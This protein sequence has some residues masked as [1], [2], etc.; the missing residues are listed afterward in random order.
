MELLDTGI[1]GTAFLLDSITPLV[2]SFYLIVLNIPFYLL[3]LKKLGKEFVVYSLFAIGVFSVFIFIFRNVLP[4]DF[5]N[6]SPFAGED[7]LLCALF[8]GLLS[9]LG[10]GFVI[11]FG[12]AIDGVEVMAVLFAKRLSLTVGTFVMCYNLLIYTFSGLIFQ[13]WLVPMYSVIAYTVGVKTID[14][15]VE[16]LDKAKAVFIVTEKGSDI[17]NQLTAALGRGVTTLD[18][19]GVY[20][21]IGKTLIYCVA[22]RFEIHRIKTIVKDSDDSAFVTISDVSE[23][24]GGI[25]INLNMKKKNKQKDAVVTELLLENEEEKLQK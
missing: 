24:V 15:V 18:A 1:S 9:G 17:Q 11:R 13:S 7:M 10:S 5:T 4:I 25:E 16:G 21:N 6:G 23:T 8:G 19:H 22:N 14:F 12:G 20:S 2:M 3:A